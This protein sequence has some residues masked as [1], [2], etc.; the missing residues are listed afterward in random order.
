MIFF[1]FM[2]LTRKKF[3][4]FEITS[5]ICANCEISQFNTTSTMIWCVKSINKKWLNSKFRTTSLISWMLQKNIEWIESMHIDRSNCENDWRISFNVVFNIADVAFCAVYNFYLLTI[6]F[7]LFIVL[8]EKL[9]ENWLYE[10][11]LSKKNIID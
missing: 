2:N 8:I 9:T 4:V 11:S 6:S 3:I 5:K 7:N 10:K 1:S